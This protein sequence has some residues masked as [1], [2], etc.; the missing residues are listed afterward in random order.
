M[1]ALAC[2]VPG[3]DLPVLAMSHLKEKGMPPIDTL[4]DAERSAHMRK[5]KSKNT[6][7]ERLLARELR[8]LGLNPKRND[9]LR[10]GKPDFSFVRKRVAVFVDGDFWHGRCGVP[11]TNS[12]WWTEKFR[13]NAA[14][15]AR[16]STELRDAG[17][18]VLRFWEKDIVK[19]GAAALAAA[20]VKSMLEGR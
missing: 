14:R 15:D 16:Q 2:A 8:R 5:I 4:P 3:A 10:P 18:L 6:K 9:R 1:T 12:A 19:K 13:R 17:W 11:K 7:P 20:H